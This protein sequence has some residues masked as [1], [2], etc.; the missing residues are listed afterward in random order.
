MNL[1]GVNVSE[2]DAMI[3][4]IPETACK[5]MVFVIGGLEN[6]IRDNNKEG[7]E[8]VAIREST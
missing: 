2:T 3:T 1:A 8:K 6:N 5:V 7:M 4:G